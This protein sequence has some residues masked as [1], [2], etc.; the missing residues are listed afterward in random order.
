MDSSDS[1]DEFYDRTKKPVKPAKNSAV[2][3]VNSICM[4]LQ[5]QEKEVEELHKQLQVGIHISLGLLHCSVD[6]WCKN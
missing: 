3:T 5:G 6:M 2:L 1:D 4:K